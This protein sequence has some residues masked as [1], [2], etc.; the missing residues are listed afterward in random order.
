MLITHFRGLLLPALLC[1]CSLVHAQATLPEVKQYDESLL[2]LKDCAFD[3]GAAAMVL[4][5][6]AVTTY[7][8]DDGSM[9]TEVRKRIKVF[10]KNGLEEG[11]FIIPYYSKNQFETI[12]KVE[13]ESYSAGPNGSPV[14]T[15][16]GKDMIFKENV[17]QYRSQVKVLVPNVLE[18]SVFEVRY[19]SIMKHYG[20]L[21]YWDF[22]EEIPVAKSCYWLEI[23]PGSEFAYSVQ[24]SVSL[25]IDIKPN[26]EMG[27]MY[28]E[29]NDVPS[30]AFEPY[31]DAPSNYLQRVVFQLSAYH[32]YRNGEQTK[33]NTTWDALVKELLSSEM[34][35]R[36]LG[37][38]LEVPGLAEQVNALSSNTEKTRLLY[39][40][41]RNKISWDKYYSKYSTRGVKKTLADGVGN[42]CEVNLLLLNLLQQFNIPSHPLLV[43]DRDFGKIDV[44]YPFLDKFSK[45]VV[46][47]E[48]EKGVWIMDATEKDLPAHLT[49]YQL[50]N[51]IALV[52]DKKQPRLI[53]IVKGKDRFDKRV[54]VESKID[55]AKQQISSQVKIERFGYAKLP[56]GKTVMGQAINPIADVDE[57][58]SL[59]VEVV[60]SE[61]LKALFDSLPNVHTL[62]LKDELPGNVGTLYLSSPLFLGLNQN[63]FSSSRRFS[64]VNFG[65]PISMH[66]HETIALPA[67]AS[68]KEA[69]PELLV[70]YDK[71]QITVNRKVEL[72]DNQ[73]TIDTHF[74]Q[75]ITLVEAKDYELLRDFYGRMMKM[76]ETPVVLALP[77]P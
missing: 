37:K 39:N 32:N 9:V 67:G 10:N 61:K 53:K 11:N 75:N 68:L 45:M 30:L 24:K 71:S 41:V 5:H 60:K 66:Q 6:S 56:P 13:G 52:V 59:T 55:L 1:I 25:P 21:D 20:G 2:K 43:A 42:T 40:F 44:N 48:L 8:H 51:T 76:L 63:P 46:Y 47:A 65:Y 54:D 74:V 28:F 12:I 35:G 7:N 27:K 38:N 70:T 57:E 16:V 18:G 36:E 49:P 77:Q 23:P 15:K 58:K 34:Y 31:M 50:L 19:T 72:K 17:D 14:I 22:Q 26:P 64:D 69:F 29:M 3:S 4:F 33:V 73:L 62:E